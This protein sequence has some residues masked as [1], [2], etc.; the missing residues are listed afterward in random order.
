MGD[1]AEIPF[2]LLPFIGL[3][4]GLILGATGVAVGGAA[5]Y[6]IPERY[7]KSGG[8]VLA[9]VAGIAV[10]ALVGLSL[11]EGRQSRVSWAA[12][13]LVQWY[14]GFA[15]ACL[16]ANRWVLLAMVVAGIVASGVFVSTVIGMPAG[17]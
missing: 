9:V 3:F 12:V 5:R 7:R 6:G 17:G 16:G 8:I 15:A 4:A 2:A 10:A 13:F 11:A 14:P 1:A